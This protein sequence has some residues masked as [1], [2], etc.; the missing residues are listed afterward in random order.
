MVDSCSADITSTVRI[1]CAVC[2][3]L[4]LCV[5]CFCSGF[6][7]SSHKPY[8]S[9]R[10]IERNVF[11]IFDDDWGADEELLLIEGC[12][13]YG[14]GN[15]ADIAEHI[16]SKT[17][18]EC[19]NHYMTVYINSPTFPLP[20]MDTQV[21]KTAEEL[22]ESRKNQI[23]ARR[24]LIKQAPI[25]KSKPFS[26][27]PSN[28]EIQ[29]YM[30]GRLEFETELENEAEMSIKD[31]EFAFDEDQTEI[32]L[33]LTVLNIY[34]DKLARRIDR[35]RLIFEH[36]LLE[37]RKNQTNDKKRNRDERE[38]VQQIRQ[39]ARLQNASSYEKF[40]ENLVKELH[41]RNRIAELQD[42]RKNGLVTFEQGQ[43][44]EQDKIQRRSSSLYGPIGIR[45]LKS[46]GSDGLVNGSSRLGSIDELA[47]PKIR[48]PAT[49]LN[50]STSTDVH[51][52]SPAEQ[53]LCSQLRILPKPY[54]A[55]K[56]TLMRELVRS[57]GNLRKRQAR[58]LIKI[59]VNKTGRIFEFFQS[60][61]WLNHPNAATA[62]MNRK[63]EQKE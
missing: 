54:I 13:I 28:H 50:I 19:E 12:E 1:R 29:G 48:K 42:W 26:S 14:L 59:D 37:Y 25:V 11:P 47:P 36:N 4:D 49:P 31:I 22:E 10:V 21:T 33:K 34:N 40:T 55:I 9:Y 38:L 53:A 35:R 39:Y 46:Y 18:E 24:Q 58:E 62:E 51:L 2:E 27:T 6:E 16:G 7:N 30:P 8:H 60:Q 61:G 20:V 17:K 5:S 23:E 57:G 3:D 32:D 52:L 44:Y 15:W 63:A 56:E 41:I 45:S 43:K